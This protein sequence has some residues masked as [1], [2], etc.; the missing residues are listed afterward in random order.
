MWIYDTY[1]LFYYLL[2]TLTD[3]G[4]E[5][6][7]LFIDKV[8]EAFDMNNQTVNLTTT[9]NQQPAIAIA[10]PDTYDNYNHKQVRAKSAN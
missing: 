4:Y 2:D 6:N 8:E 3:E 9:S 10:T 5:L 7:S 1:P